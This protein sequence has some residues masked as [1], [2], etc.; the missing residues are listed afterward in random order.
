MKNSAWDT[1]QKRKLCFIV[2]SPSAQTMF[3]NSVY[4]DLYDCAPEV[5]LQTPKPRKIQSYLKVTFGVPAKVTQK[6][7]EGDSKVT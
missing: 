3:W 2:V 1:P 7:L 5:L 4:A 6:L